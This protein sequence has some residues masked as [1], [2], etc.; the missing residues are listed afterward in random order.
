MGLLK[1]K[2]TMQINAKTISI[3]VTAISAIASF[4]SGNISFNPE[5]YQKEKAAINR[6]WK[7]E[8][9][10]EKSEDLRKRKQAIAD[11][12]YQ[13]GCELI[14]GEKLRNGKHF[15]TFPTLHKDLPV[16]DRYTGKPMPEGKVVCDGYGNT[17]LVDV[18]GKPDENSFAS[19]GNRDLVRTII[20]RYR[21]GHY[22]QPGVELY[23][24]PVQKQF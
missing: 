23:A 13:D 21:G 12:R 10:L 2:K 24:Q 4:A 15:F 3:G 19:T 7:R 6:S 22:A 18:D 20:D 11:S 14:V 17:A 16:F 8:Q 1:R 9:A 5:Q